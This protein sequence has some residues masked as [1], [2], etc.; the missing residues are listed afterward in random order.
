MA[1]NPDLALVEF[2][3]WT[4]KLQARFFAGGLCVGGRGLVEGATAVVD[5]RFHS[6]KR[7]NITFTAR[8]PA[9]PLATSVAADERQQHLDA[10]AAHH[11]Q[12]EIWAANCPENFENR[13]A[14]VGAEIARIDGRDAR[15]DAPL[16]T[17]HPLGPRKR[18]YS[19]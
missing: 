4:R 9:P 5:A 8:C 3:Y 6:S 13:A 7:R 19:Q 11:K 12:L 1:A 15:R 2:C 17:G 18:L 16:R 14:L 10:V